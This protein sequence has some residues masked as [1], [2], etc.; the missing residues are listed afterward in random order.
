MYGEFVHNKKY[1]RDPVSNKATL[2]ISSTAI[3]SS[4]TKLQQPLLAIVANG[5]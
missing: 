3:Q 4:Q 5:H 2:D 1:N